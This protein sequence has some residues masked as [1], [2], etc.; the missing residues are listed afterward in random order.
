MIDF[1]AD[2]KDPG[3]DVAVVHP[4][5]DDHKPGFSARGLKVQ[6]ANGTTAGSRQDMFILISLKAAQTWRLIALGSVK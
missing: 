1:S 3:A 2:G 4:L 5:G 6:P